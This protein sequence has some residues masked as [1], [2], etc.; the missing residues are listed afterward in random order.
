MGGGGSPG[1][2]RGPPYAQMLSPYKSAPEASD[3]AGVIKSRLERAKQLDALN[4]QDVGVRLE[5][6]G[7]RGNAWRQARALAKLY[8]EGKATRERAEREA[9]RLEL[10]SA[11]QIIA[12][13][14]EGI[15]D[16][17]P[18]GHEIDGAMNPARR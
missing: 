18:P 3:V 1:G 9:D 5:N 12:D 10:S 4:W 15:A 17:V 11:L 2:L 7:E 8:R 14:I 13:A 6:I 16:A